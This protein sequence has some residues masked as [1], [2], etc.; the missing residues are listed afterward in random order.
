MR[1]DNRSN[2]QMRPVRFVPNFTKHAT[3]SVLVEFGDTKVI[4]TVCVSDGVPHFLRNSQPA[5]GWLTAEY[6]MLPG[7]TNTRAKRERPA[8]S[9]RSQE[10]QRLIGRS[11]RGVFDLTKVPDLTFNVDCDVIQADGGTRTSAI[12]GAYVALK[13]ACDKLSRQ[14]KIRQN[15]LSDS[16][17]AVSI[18]L[19]Q[20]EILVDLDY[21]EDSTADL[22]MNV[23][24]TGDG[25][26]LEIQGTA[27]RASFTK[28]QVLD[29]IEAAEGALS[30]MN[31]LQNL[32]AEG[33][34]VES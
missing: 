4:C 30:P 5:Q 23:V 11:L 29:I 22:D 25:R 27:E 9:G 24:L 32:A 21:S 17:S 14:G 3:G 34:T 16:V 8:P 20:D 10:I 12:T 19:K 7:S 13:I 28:K 26:I 31:E 33:E 15:P 6:S 2:T 1:S 18:G